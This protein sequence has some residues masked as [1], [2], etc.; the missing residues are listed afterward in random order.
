MVGYTP[1][2]GETSLRKHD[3]SEGF[4]ALALASSKH[5]ALICMTMDRNTCVKVYVI[6]ART[7]I[8]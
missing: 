8:R 1:V 2:L 6:T 5:L 4:L 7:G 3:V